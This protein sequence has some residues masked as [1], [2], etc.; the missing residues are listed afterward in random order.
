[1]RKKDRLLPELISSLPLV[2]T[3]VLV[4]ANATLN[5]T[6]SWRQRALTVVPNWVSREQSSVCATST[7]TRS[8]WTCLESAIGR[9]LCE[10]FDPARRRQRTHIAAAWLEKSRVR[11]KRNSSA[12]LSR[13]AVSSKPTGC[14]L[15]RREQTHHLALCRAPRCRA[16]RL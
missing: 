7:L 2:C 13:C 5:R 15:Q 10:L 16:R 4:S 6:D 14:M 11:K 1:M 3:G 8:T 12:T 9:S